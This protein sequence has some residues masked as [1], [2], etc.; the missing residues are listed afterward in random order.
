MKAIINFYLQKKHWSKIQVSHLPRMT[1]SGG[2]KLLTLAVRMLVLHWIAPLPPTLLIENRCYLFKL[3]FFQQP[4]TGNSSKVNS[5]DVLKIRSH[6]LSYLSL[7]EVAPGAQHSPRGLSCYCLD[8]R[9]PYQNTS[10]SLSCS[11]KAPERVLG[12]GPSTWTPANHV[13]DTPGVI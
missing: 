11:D 12:D 10:S 13:E 6:V 5:N 3:V 7:Q 1:Q 8:A 4:N 2:A 9:I